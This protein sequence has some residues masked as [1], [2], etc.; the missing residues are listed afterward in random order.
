MVPFT[1]SSFLCQCC[2]VIKYTVADR[3]W[4]QDGKLLIP[5]AIDYIKLHKRFSKSPINQKILCEQC[6]PG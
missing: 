1:L 6:W 4:V 3:R 2:S 5:N